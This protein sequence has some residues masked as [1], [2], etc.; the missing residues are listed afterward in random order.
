[1]KFQGTI[2]INRPVET[3]T[4]LFADPKYLG[5]YQEGFVR[6]EL[7]SGVAREDGA[8]SKMYYQQGKHEMVL[9]ETIVANR[10]PERFEAFYHHKHMDNT[11]KCSFTALPE[12]GTRYHTEVE[13]TRI[14]WVMPKLFALLFPGM[15]KKPAR[16]WLENFK[17]FVESHE[18]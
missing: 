2:E 3:V 12:G 18:G 17:T 1:M 9:T 15:Y 6:K 7:E 13:Y 14:D 11:L 8:V 4:R 16:R 5:S 10:L